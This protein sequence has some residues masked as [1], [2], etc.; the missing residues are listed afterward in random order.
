MFCLFFLQGSPSP[1]PHY[2][3]V[4]FRYLGGDAIVQ[5]N[6]VQGVIV[7]NKFLKILYLIGVFFFI[8]H[9]LAILKWTINP[10]F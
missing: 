8:K 10:F 4:F 5:C 6:F 3:F 1:E 2:N 9:A 7:I